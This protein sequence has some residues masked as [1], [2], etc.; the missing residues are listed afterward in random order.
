MENFHLY[1]TSKPPKPP[2]FSPDDLEYCRRGSVLCIFATFYFCVHNLIQQKRSSYLGRQNS[3]VPIEKYETQIS[4]KKGWSA[5]LSIKCAQFSLTLAWAYVFHKVQGL[6]LEQEVTDCDL[7]MEKIFGQWKMYTA[8]SR[9]KTYD[10]IFIKNKLVSINFKVVPISSRVKLM[11]TISC[12][13]TV[14]FVTISHTTPV[15]FSLKF[16]IVF[17][18]LGIDF[19]PIQ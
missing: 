7:R 6:S 4:I 11:R 14:F 15:I 18:F 1:T 9:V 8:L 16:I 3:S 17:N 13:F 10:I 19:T 12:C 5:S 2:K